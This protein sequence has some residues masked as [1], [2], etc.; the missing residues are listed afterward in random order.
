LRNFLTPFSGKILSPSQTAQLAQRRPGAGG[1]H[2]ILFLA[3]GYPHDFHGI[4]D[5]VGGA[6]LAFWTA[7]H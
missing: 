4:T 5:H 7:R 3:S 6:F 2:Y 1:R